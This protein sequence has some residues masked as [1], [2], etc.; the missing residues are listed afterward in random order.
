MVIAFTYGITTATSILINESS[1]WFMSS[2]VNVWITIIETTVAMRNPFTLVHFQKDNIQ[3]MFVKERS[4]SK[5]DISELFWFLSEYQRAHIKLQNVHPLKLSQWQKAT[6]Q[7]T[8]P[9]LQ[10]KISN[11]CPDAKRLRQWFSLISLLFPPVEQSIIFNP[12]LL[13]KIF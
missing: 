2:Q 6:W 1:T 11:H 9:E 4:K 12:C 7:K 3:G 13:Y 8:C 5:A 10:S